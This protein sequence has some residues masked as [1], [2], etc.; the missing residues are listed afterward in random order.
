MTEYK[1]SK[2]ETIAG[3]FGW[4]WLARA[5]LGRAPTESE[6]VT[7]FDQLVKDGV[8][9]YDYSFLTEIRDINGIRFEFRISKALQN[10]PWDV[11]ASHSLLNGN[12]R[13]GSDINTTETE[14]CGLNTTHFLVFNGFASYR[15]HYMILTTDGYRR[16]QEPLNIEDFRAVHAFIGM[17]ESEHLL[18]YNCKPEAGCSRNHKHLQAIPKTSYDGNSWF[19]LEHCKDALPFKYFEMELPQEL[20]PE[21][22]LALYQEGLH[23]VEQALDQKTTEETGAPP[24]NILMD[25]NRM[26]MIPRRAAGID[27]LGANSGGMLGMIWVKSEEAMHQ[28]LEIGPD[29][30]IA[31][32]GVPK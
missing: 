14:L 27:P 16:Q 22:M 13:P 8:I 28:W 10:K 32:G 23:Q 7:A 25:R 9:Q 19:N 17:Q 1:E 24:H 31:A 20:S 30:I 11:H 3:K 26:V 5:S 18:F 12:V 15:P 2:Q 4:P 6:L 21:A 29:K